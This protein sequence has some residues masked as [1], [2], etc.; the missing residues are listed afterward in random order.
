MELDKVGKKLFGKR[1]LG[2]VPSDRVPPRRPDPYF[3]ANLHT[4]VM[5]GLH[6]VCSY[7][8]SDGNSAWHDPLARLGQAQRRHHDFERHVRQWTDEESAPHDQEASENN[9]G[10]RCL[11]ALSVAKSGGF[12]SYV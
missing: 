7:V 5:P 10:Q 1:W 11:V 9:C 3:I 4:A 6:W 2:V 8:D 12:K